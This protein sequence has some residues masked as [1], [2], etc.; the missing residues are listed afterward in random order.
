MGSEKP[1]RKSTIIIVRLPKKV[2]EDFVEVCEKNGISGSLLAQVFAQY[3]IDHEEVPFQIALRGY[4]ITDFAQKN[5][6]RPFAKEQQIPEEL[7]DA[8]RKKRTDNQKTPE[9]LEELAKQYKSKQVV[10]VT[11]VTFSVSLTWELREEFARAAEN[12]LCSSNMLLRALMLYVA[13][14]GEIPSALLPLCNA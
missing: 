5:F 7:R 10:D 1:E 9:E 13:T 4:N 12:L 11:E 14:T 8:K 6:Y 3:V 2:K